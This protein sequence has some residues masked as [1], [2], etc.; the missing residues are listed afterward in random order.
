LLLLQRLSR[1]IIREFTTEWNTVSTQKLI[2]LCDIIWIILTFTS[3]FVLHWFFKIEILFCFS[4]LIIWRRNIHLKVFT[5]FL[6]EGR[7]WERLLSR[8]D[9]AF[10][11]VN[12][13]FQIYDY[14]M[15]I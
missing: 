11:Y 2:I 4:L 3:S 15:Q 5:N 13:Q 12:L 10:L 1:K 14:K 9:G 7:D 8:V 6:W